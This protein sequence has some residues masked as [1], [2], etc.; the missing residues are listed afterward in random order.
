MAPKI[1]KN[2]FIFN[3]SLNKK[4]EFRYSNNLYETSVSKFNNFGEYTFEHFFS[5]FINNIFIDYLDLNYNQFIIWA[6]NNV[7]IF[8]PI[9]IEKFPKFKYLECDF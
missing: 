6:K 1:L 9:F 3:K 4:Y 2:Q 5:R 7:N 8:F